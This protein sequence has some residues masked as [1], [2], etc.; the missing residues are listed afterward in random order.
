L[1]ARAEAIAATPPVQGGYVAKFTFPLGISEVYRVRLTEASDIQLAHDI[2]AGKVGPMVPVGR[3]VHGIPD[4]NDGWS[5]HIDPGSFGFADAAIE[6]CDGLP[7]HVE[8][9]LITSSYYCPWSAI[10]SQLDPAPY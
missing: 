4:V 1:G 8:A 10:L 9:Q 5:W 7:S 2:L 3:V 6:V